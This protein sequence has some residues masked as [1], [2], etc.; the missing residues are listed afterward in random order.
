M[1]YSPWKKSKTKNGAT[2]D[3]TVSADVTLSTLVA[4]ISAAGGLSY[5]TRLIEPVNNS[6]GGEPGGNIRV[7]FLFRTDRGLAFIDRAV[8]TLPDS[9]RYSYVF[10]GNS[11]VLDHI[12]VTPALSGAALAGFDL[13]HVNAEFAQQTS[14][15][16]PAVAR[17]TL[18]S[19]PTER[20]RPVLE[21]VVQ[22]SGFYTAYFGYLNPNLVPVSVPA[23]TQNKFTP[24]PLERGQPTQFF[25]GRQAK[26][27]A[28][29]FPDGNLVW[30]LT[31]RTSTASPNSKRCR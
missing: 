15:H 6:D 25:P 24:A 1:G 19:A 2:N 9:E 7:A 28:V 17:F 16:D 21:C 18:G 8:E 31:G 12:M 27:F 13:V 10:D 14:D 20:V 11:Q 29:D 4:A 30:S 23:G 26:V 22:Q 3:G 5:S